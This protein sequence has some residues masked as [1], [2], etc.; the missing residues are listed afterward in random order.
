MHCVRSESSS[1]DYE[2]DMIITWT[3]VISRC[4]SCVGDSDPYAIL[5]KGRMDEGTKE[6]VVP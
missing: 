2:G 3:F 5:R 1:E 6:Q 4:R